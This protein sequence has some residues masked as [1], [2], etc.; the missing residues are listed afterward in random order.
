MSCRISFGWPRALAAVLLV[1]SVLALP[2]SNA[3]AQPVPQVVVTATRSE[4]AITDTLASTTV[5]TREDISDTQAPDLATLLRSAA[6]IEVTQNGGPGTVSSVFMRG[7]NSN[8]TLILLDGMRINSAT[9]GTTALESLTLDQIERVEIVRGNVSALYGSEAIGGVIQLFTRQGS[10]APALG[11]SLTTGAR[12]TLSGNLNYGGKIGDT[13]FYIGLAGFHTAG[14][15]AIA[16]DTDATTRANVNPDKDGYRNTTINANVAHMFNPRNEA[17]LRFFDTRGLVNFDNAFA[18]AATDVQQSRNSTSSFTAYSKNRFL[19]AWR[20]TLTYSKSTDS[21]DA[22]LNYRWNGHI[23]TDQRQLSWQNEIT[24]A[25]THKLLFSAENL[26]QRAESESTTSKYY[27]ARKVNSLLAGYSG[28]V[29]RAEFQLNARS[30][31]Y[32]DFGSVNTYFAA[33]GYNVTNEW[34]LIVQQSTAFNAPTFVQLYFPGFGSPNLLPES[35]KSR[36]FGAQWSSG[37]HLLRLTHFRTDYTNLI[38]GATVA[39][40]LAIN[41]AKARV[42][43]WESNYTGAWYGFDLRANVT[44]Q[45]PVTIPADAA[46]GPQ[47]RRRAQAFG[48]IGIYR[49]IGQ[50]RFGADLYSTDKRVD[51]EITAF[52]TQKVGLASYNLLTLTA[53]YN[54]TKE[55]YVAAKLDNASNARYQVVHGF[56]TPQRGFFLTFG[57]QPK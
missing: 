11:A 6:G 49:S 24:L 25:P 27:P 3:F 33:A 18:A 55:M 16:K 1:L 28:S 21:N 23:R 52:P 50:W 20:S 39:P 14:F 53:R 37:S 35:A 32:S 7:S 12:G 51:A 48:N 54:I 47:L 34:K 40:F 44:L 13:R 38:I 17:G 26:S 15:S 4:Q 31:R 22:L 5:L 46:L 19:D 36:E 29:E 41:V 30:D 9:T 45:D 57:Y 42:N 2:L 43:G 10:G 56:N 8:H